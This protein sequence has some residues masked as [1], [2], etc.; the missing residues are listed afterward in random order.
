MIGGVDCVLDGLGKSNEEL[1]DGAVRSICRH[2][3]HACFEDAITG[4]FFESYLE[5]G[6]DGIRELFVY[7]TRDAFESWAE[8]G[9]IDDNLNSM[10]HLLIDGGQL[11]LVVDAIEDDVTREILAEIRSLTNVWD[12][13]A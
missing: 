6:F 5:L 7:Q 8:Y 13:A 2:W 3:Q 1:L 11:T 9:A 4:D 10:I 12:L